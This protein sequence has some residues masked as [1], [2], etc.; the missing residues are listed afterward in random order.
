[1]MIV[2]IVFC[3]KVLLIYLE[4]NINSFL[5]NSSNEDLVLLFREKDLLFIYKESTDF[6]INHSSYSDFI[7]AMKDNFIYTQNEF[8]KFQMQQINLN[9]M[10]QEILNKK[11]FDLGKQFVLSFMKGEQNRDGNYL[12]ISL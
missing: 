1:M 8:G 7:F 6:K 10:V 2:N 12:N 11:E 3:L 9:E 5:L 4:T